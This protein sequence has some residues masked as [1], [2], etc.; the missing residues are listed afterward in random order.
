M[1]RRRSHRELSMHG[2]VLRDHGCVG[3]R[4]AGFCRTLRAALSAS[5]H[6]AS[7]LFEQLQVRWGATLRNDAAAVQL[8]H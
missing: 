1:L 2:D 4:Y 8:L 5:V 3:Q 7:S 6:I